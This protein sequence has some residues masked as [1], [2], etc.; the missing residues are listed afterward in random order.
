MKINKLTREVYAFR[1]RMFAHHHKFVPMFKTHAI[2]QNWQIIILFS[3]K[4]EKIEIF[5]QVYAPQI[6]VKISE[7]NLS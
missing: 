5:K 2:F 3:T 7:T 4:L 1:L 6:T